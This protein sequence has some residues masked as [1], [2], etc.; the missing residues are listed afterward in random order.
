MTVDQLREQLR[1]IPGDAEI[2]LG[3]GLLTRASFDAIKA[4]R[5]KD[6]PGVYACGEAANSLRNV[7]EREP[8]YVLRV[9]LL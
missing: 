2:V 1:T 5:L 3:D 9:N 8:V 4:H 6:S 7:I